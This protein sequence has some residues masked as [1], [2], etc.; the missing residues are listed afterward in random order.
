MAAGGS[1]HANTN[2]LGPITMSS[3]ARI[4]VYTDENQLHHVSVYIEEPDGT[5][6]RTQSEP[7]RMLRDNIEGIS[8]P[9]GDVRSAKFDKNERHWQSPTVSFHYGRPQSI[10]QF[11]RQQLASNRFYVFTKPNLSGRIIQFTLHELKLKPGTS[12][13]IL[14]LL[15]EKYVEAIDLWSKDQY[16]AYMN[17]GKPTGVGTRV[18][19]QRLIDKKKLALQHLKESHRKT[20]RLSDGG[21]SQPADVFIR[22]D[23]MSIDP[24]DS[25]RANKKNSKIH[26]SPKPAQ[27][28]SETAS[29]DHERDHFY[30]RFMILTD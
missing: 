6:K 29:S 19:K 21:G 28:K 17:Q 22:Y 24:D 1:S 12:Q 3:F 11:L 2:L 16:L 7:L 14:K 20:G 8:T 13:Q 10:Y 23:T 26:R 5:F 25:L 30:Q 9:Q 18:R 27:K 15:K 4:P